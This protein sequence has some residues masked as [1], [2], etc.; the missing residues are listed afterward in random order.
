MYTPTVKALATSD[1]ETLVSLAWPWR[2]TDSP[3]AHVLLVHGLGEHA[4]RYDDL[5]MW[6][7]HQGIGV[8]AYDQ[9]GHGASSG[10]RA[11]L[12]TADALLDDLDVVWQQF[13]K[14]QTSG[15]PLLLLGHSMGGL[16]VM[17]WLQRHAGANVGQ[18]PAPQAAIVSSPA[19]GVH[20]SG[21]EQW[22]VKVLS[23]YAPN[24]RLANGLKLQ[25]LSHDQ[26]VIE[27]YKKDPL[28]HKYIT[29][30][31]A[32]WI[33]SSGQQVVDNAHSWALPTLLMYAGADAL[34]DPKA[35]DAFARAA[36][37]LVQ[38]QRLD[39]AYHEIF[40]ESALYRDVALASLG[41]WLDSQ[42]Q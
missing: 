15:V 1:G 23:Q 12:P 9:R 34:V 18:A 10:A 25:A 31:L 42:L 17:R 29:P 13:A 6:F 16:V 2:R 37:A 7:Q 39:A 5:A 4:R 19:L 20:A 38:A 26:A 33:V 27:A 14:A 21:V 32:H 28:V 22:L 35:A 36:P 24:V 40:N 8:W 11:T 41:S 3:R 30:K